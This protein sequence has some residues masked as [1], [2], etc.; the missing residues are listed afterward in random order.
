MDNIT[1]DTVYNS[2]NQLNCR[3]DDLNNRV[4]ETNTTMRVFMNETSKSHRDIG[5]QMDQACRLISNVERKSSITKQ[6]LEDHLSVHKKEDEKIN[7]NGIKITSLIGNFTSAIIGAF[8]VLYAT[9][10]L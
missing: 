9:G 4:D 6:R 7:I 3:I 2:I 5:R 1:L 8:A 10:T